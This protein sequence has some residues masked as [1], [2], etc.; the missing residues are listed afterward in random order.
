MKEKPG[1]RFNKNISCLNETYNRLSDFLNDKQTVH[2][3]DADGIVIDSP[4]QVIS[5]FNKQVL[6]Q[7]GIETDP[8]EVDRWGY[9]TYFSQLNDLPYEVILKAEDDW[10]D[11]ETLEK[12][13]RYSWIKPV[14]LSSLNKSGINRNFILT[15]RLPELKQTTVDWFSKHFPDFD[16]DN[17]LI[18]E[19]LT[20]DPSTFKAETVAF[21]AEKYPQVIVYEDSV[22]YSKAILDEELPNCI[23]ILVP[24]G[25]IRPGFD[26]DNLIVLRR[27]PNELQAMYPLYDLVKRAKDKRDY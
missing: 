7:F 12:S 10:Y 8:S 16:S 5:Q 11:S 13:P 6:S 14:L 4:R 17:I 15:A 25:N 26:N 2:L 27:Y 20:D 18:R 3:Y 1:Y 22:E 9:L 19:S 24:L 23:V 21:F